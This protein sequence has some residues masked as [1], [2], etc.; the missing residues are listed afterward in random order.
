MIKSGH[1]QTNSIHDLADLPARVRDIATLRGLGYSYREIGLRYAITPQ[2]VSLM[3]SRHKRSLASLR[4]RSELAGLSS[5]ATNVL[6]RIGL[7][8]REQ[9]AA[10][11]LSTLLANQ[12]NCGAKTKS[13]IVSWAAEC[14]APHT[15]L[16]RAAGG[17][18]GQEAVV[19]EFQ[20]VEA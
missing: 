18:H 16:S 19:R 11:D 2:A 1:I 17:N 7:A 12:R 8:T 20:L 9:A 14:R 6:G 10:C 13:E 4:G 5:R 15:A 3:L